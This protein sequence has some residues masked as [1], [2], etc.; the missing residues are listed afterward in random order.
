MYRYVF[1]ANFYTFAGLV[2]IILWG[3]KRPF[4]E[5]KKY[6]RGQERNMLPNF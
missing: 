4:L 6:G 1:Y 3:K 5:K 2:F